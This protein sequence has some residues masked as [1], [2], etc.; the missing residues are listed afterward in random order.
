M[1]IVCLRN[2]VLRIFVL[3]LC[4]LFFVPLVTSEVTQTAAESAISSAQDQI[5]NCYNSAKIAEGAGANITILQFALNKAGQSLSNAELAYSN[6][7]YTS[8]I[9]YANQCQSAL[10]N[11]VSD[12]NALKEKGVQQQNENLAVFVGS[13]AG[14]FAVAVAGYIVWLRIKKKSVK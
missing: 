7:D 14:S 13:I 5:I 6:G 4:F 11:F 12:S 9:N 10:I 8:A 1:K 2:T 3:S